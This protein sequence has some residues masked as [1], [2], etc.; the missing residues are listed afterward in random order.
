MVE[1]AN[2]VLNSCRLGSS[3]ERGCYVYW[4]IGSSATIGIGSNFE[5]NITGSNEHYFLMVALNT[6]KA[7][8]RNGA[9]TMSAQ[10]RVNGGHVIT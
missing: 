9:V 1:M 5:G 7:L 4:Q 10:E 8:A 2:R 6:G 3:V